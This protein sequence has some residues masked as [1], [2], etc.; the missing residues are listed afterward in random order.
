MTSPYANYFWGRTIERLRMENQNMDNEQPVT[1]TKKPRRSLD[2]RQ[3]DLR[4]KL[5]ELDAQRVAKA[6]RHEQEAVDALRSMHGA[7]KSLPAADQATYVAK[8]V[9]AARALGVTL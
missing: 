8:A 1:E 7:S 2:E 4:T 5:A 3:A 6:K 9:N